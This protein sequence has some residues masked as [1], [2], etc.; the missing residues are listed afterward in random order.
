MTSN[1]ERTEIVEKLGPVDY[2]IHITEFQKHGPPHGHVA[3]KLKH[4]LWTADEID[5]FL[6]AELPREP[7]PVR[8][9]IKK[10]MSHQHDPKKEYHRCGWSATSHRCQYNYPHL[11]KP[12]SGFNER[13][14][15]VCSLAHQ[16][17]I[18]LQ[19]TMNL[20][21]YGG[22]CVHRSPYPLLG[23]QI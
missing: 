7:G 8:D 20:E 9:T 13:G 11:T 2:S 23:C 21:T 5:K 1:P 19:V 4:V 17:L 22:G 3:V 16:P 10:H 6:S 12:D 14:M 18:M 15:S